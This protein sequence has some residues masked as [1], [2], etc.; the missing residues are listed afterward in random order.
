MLLFGE[1]IDLPRYCDYEINDI[2]TISQV[3]SF[4]YHKPH[5]NY[6][7]EGLDNKNDCE[8]FVDL[9]NNLVVSSQW[10]SVMIVVHGEAYGVY[11][12]AHSN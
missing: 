6:F 1:I 8:C 11:Y 2:P 9:I 5:S 3:W 7:E 12:D 4:V 10:F